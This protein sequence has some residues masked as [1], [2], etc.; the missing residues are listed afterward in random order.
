[1]K[2]T[3]EEI[4]ERNV[5]KDFH[6]KV[7]QEDSNFVEIYFENIDRELKELSHQQLW[8]CEATASVRGAMPTYPLKK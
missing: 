1:M 7:M 2:L 3:A 6:Q 5:G 8:G 4:V